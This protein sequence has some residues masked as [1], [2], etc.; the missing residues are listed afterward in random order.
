MPAYAVF[1][2]RNITL[3]PILAKVIGKPVVD[4]VAVFQVFPPSS[5]YSKSARTSGAS[6]P[7]KA[8]VTR[9]TFFL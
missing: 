1:A 2:P 7:I 5:L 4:V 3:S 8:V 9:V 6:F